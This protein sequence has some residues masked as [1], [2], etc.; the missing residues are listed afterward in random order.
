MK[1]KLICLALVLSM[2]L[3]LVACGTAN[4]PDNSNPPP[5][6]SAEPP[7]QSI[8]CDVTRFA[9]ISSA[10]LVKLLGE[11]NGISETTPAAG[12][13]EIPCTYYDYYDNEILGDVSF[14]LIN[15]AVVKF[16][17]YHEFPY[18]E[19]GEVLKNLNVQK[20]DSCV[21]ATDT[22]TALRFRCLTDEI[23]DLHITLIE[24]NHYGF[25]GV[26]YDMVYF[27]EWYLPLSISEKSDYQ[28]WTQEYVRSILKS[29]KSADFPNIS[30]WAIVKNNFY[31]AA[32]S[33]VD[34]VNSFGAEVRSKFTF[35]YPVGS[36]TPICAVFD[37]EVILDNGY[38]PTAELVKLLVEEMAKESLIQ[39]NE[40]TSPPGESNPVGGEEAKPEA[41]TPMP[42][43]HTHS[44]GS[45]EYYNGSNH[46]HTC[47]SCRE[48]EYEAHKWS[49]GVVTREATCS[50]EGQK[51][52]SCSVCHAE[53]SE[54]IPTLAHT[55]DN[56][57]V[58]QEATCINEGVTTY[59]CTNC[60][61]EKYESIPKT[62]HEFTQQ[63]EDSKYLKS[64]A[65]YT[66]GSVYYYSC[67][68]GL[69]GT[70]VFVID[71]RIEW[72]TTEK[73]NRDFNLSSHWLHETDLIIYTAYAG[74]GGE[75]KQYLIYD[76]MRN[77][78]GNDIYTGSYNGVSVRFY[79]GGHYE[80]YVFNYD[81]LVAAGIIENPT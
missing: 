7:A 49:N 18:G 67:L 39:D 9:N 81:D 69:Q 44:Y 41:S 29:P 59:S 46:A 63:V 64:R 34:A 32:Q 43:S 8:V 62:A 15:D 4:V 35:F 16:I 76:Q 77:G 52:Y 61:T 54:S 5:S 24:G 50:Q 40:Q 60:S 38:V 65:T 33:Y 26:T 21:M 20:S 75:I 42:E 53:R 13:V 73:L 22:E 58:T 23:D 68:C 48:S 14:L 6:Q 80:G 28:Y 19:K 27:E 37:G 66:S 51:T 31:V 74:L 25:L 79:Y 10:E 72:I 57:T 70:E 47:S 17:A 56:G 1:K 3:S 30:D 36:S 78:M 11:P 12:F 55:W 2:C 71:D 45:W